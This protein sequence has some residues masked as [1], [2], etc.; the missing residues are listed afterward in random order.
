MGRW[1]DAF[2]I[3]SE[4]FDRCVRHAKIGTAIPEL[5]PQGWLLLRWDRLDAAEEMA[6]LSLQ[7]S[8]MHELRREQARSATLM[9]VIRHRQ[10]DISGA[11]H[12]FREALELARDSCDDDLIAGI[13]QNLGVLA[14]STGDLREARALYLEAI[15]ACVRAG[16]P[17]IAGSTFN[18]LGMACSDLQEWMEA[19]I[20]F[21]RGI[22][23]AVRVDDRPL[24]ALLTTGRAEPLIHTGEF[25]AAEA[26]LRRA[27]TLGL[28]LNDHVVLAD[29]HRYR[30]MIAR[31]RGDLATASEHLSRAARIAEESSLE[32]EQAEIM[33]ETAHLRRAEGRS[34]AA[35]VLLRESLH[36]Y[37]HLGARSDITRVERT[38]EKWRDREGE[39]MAQP[40]AGAG[41]AL[42]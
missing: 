42:S 8:R 18:N 31:L 29:V 35:K 40:V 26:T 32:L 17:R 13:C 34:G 21:L 10:T 2:A 9:G 6:E 37:Q 14:N 25:D 16:N 39:P 15:C 38:M 27:E 30:G 36:S 11:E 24:L 12:H 41:G 33:E 4:L 19:E 3:R 22:E 20:H 23:I 7:L 1:A 28:Q 5:V